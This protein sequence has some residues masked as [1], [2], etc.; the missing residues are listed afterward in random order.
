MA[1]E[2]TKERWLVPVDPGVPALWAFAER[3]VEPALV[4]AGV[5]GPVADVALLRHHAGRRC[6]LGVTAAGRR[7][8]AKAYRKEVGIL[9][10]LLALLGEHGLASGRAPT[11]PPLI[12]VEPALQ[13]IV[14]E[15]LEGTSGPALIAASARVGELAARWLELQ[16]SVPSP[17]GE[18][19]GRARALRRAARD[20]L[21]VREA[22]ACLGGRAASLVRHLERRAPVD[23]PPALI[24]GSFSVN[25][26]FDLGDGPGIIDWDCSSPGQREVDAATFLATLARVAGSDDALIA[27]AARAEA[28]M[29]AGLADLLEPKALSWYES[30]AL[31]TNVRHLCV[32]RHAGWETRSEGLL[33]AAEALVEGR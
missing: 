20:A 3:G 25:H 27:P 18:P 10:R 1:D 8:I 22:S 33:S 23:R 2:R 26:V 14:T 13:L 4:A 28:A 19:Y 7:L 6:T 5:P 15:R 11:A 9:A 17:A 31:L 32:A 29:R 12:A 16:W 30:A 24:H 21:A